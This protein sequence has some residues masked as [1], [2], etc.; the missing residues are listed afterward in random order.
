MSGEVL[1]APNVSVL[2]EAAAALFVAVAADAIRG[3][4][5]FAVALSGGT[6][7]RGV[8]SRLADDERLRTQVSWEH[9][10]F[11]W[12]DERHV[13]PDHP[14]SNF[15]MAYESMLGR[16]PV[17]PGHVC[18][19]KGEYES[20]AL[21]AEEY[22][23]DLRRAFRT[24]GLARRSRAGSSIARGN[25]LPRFDMVL[26]GMGADGHTASLFP[27]TEALHEGTRW[28]VSNWIPALNADRITLTPS[29][30][31][32]AAEVLFLISGDDKADALKSVIEGPYE[33]DR[34]P[35]QL[36]RPARGRLRWLVDREASRLLAGAT[37]VDV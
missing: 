11:F 19:I 13:P 8:Y 2:Q 3:R 16:L 23:R 34:L 31:N 10:R 21:A 5:V 32:N 14:D 35:A 7:P 12:G 29:V 36:I 37:I 20:A 30:L 26:L 24:T 27:G 6:T 9:V 4:G 15:H 25:Q 18:R 33:P 22:S 28:V 17:N 1:R